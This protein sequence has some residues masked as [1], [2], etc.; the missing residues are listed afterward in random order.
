VASKSVELS[1]AG[2][3]VRAVWNSLPEKFPKLVL[4]KFVVMPN[5]LYAMLGFVGAGLAP[6]AVNSAKDATNKPINAPTAPVAAV[7]NYSLAD[8]VGAFKSI[9]TIQ[10]NRPLQRKGVPLWQRSY[11]EHIVCKGEDLRKIQQYIWRI[12]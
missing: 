11:Y 6:P 4:D 9:S 10:V 1:P 3:I 12:H 5:H 2:G 7:R 8:V